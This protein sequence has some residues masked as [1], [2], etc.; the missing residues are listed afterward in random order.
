VPSGASL[1]KGKDHGEEGKEGQEGKEEE[2]VLLK[3]GRKCP[4]LFFC[5]KRR[6]RAGAL[7]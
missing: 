1:T 7:V 6:L 5:V 4:S 3:L 2:V